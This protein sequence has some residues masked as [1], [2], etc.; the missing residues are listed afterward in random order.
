MRAVL[1]D[2]QRVGGARERVSTALAPHMREGCV[3]KLRVLEDS[4]MLPSRILPYSS[5]KLSRMYSRGEPQQVGFWRKKRKPNVPPPAK[6]RASQL[7]AR[8][9]L[10]LPR[11]QTVK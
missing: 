7:G 10:T 2:D 5:S 6:I 9:L 4:R 1:Y 3:R 11:P 8:A